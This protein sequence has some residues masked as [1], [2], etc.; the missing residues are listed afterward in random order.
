MNPTWPALHT[1]LRRGGEEASPPGPLH[2]LGGWEEDAALSTGTAPLG[3]DLVPQVPPA[4]PAL[5]SGEGGTPQAGLGEGLGGEVWGGAAGR[6]S[7]LFV[8]LSGWKAG[9]EHSCSRAG[10]E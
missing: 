9:K 6:V 4:A 10:P 3:A 8:L 2:P 1:C 7:E 5:P